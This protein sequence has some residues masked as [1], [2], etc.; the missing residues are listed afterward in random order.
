MD[1]WNKLNARQLMKAIGEALKGRRV[2]KN[3]T[4]EGLSER[5][6]VSKPSISRLEAAR[7]NVSLA[8]LLSILKALEMANEL[9]II[10]KEMKASPAL[11]AKASTKK[12]K[13]RVRG[14][15]KSKKQ[16]TNF[17]WGEN[18][19]GEGKWGKDK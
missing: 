5:S 13:E 10:F 11:L 2:L 16:D 9:Q 14:S 12:T 19:G 1:D 8:N 6:G 7:G 15:K 18:K 17:V 4:Q 3:L